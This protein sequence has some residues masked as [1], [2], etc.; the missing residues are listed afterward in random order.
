MRARRWRR[1]NSRFLALARDLSERI[2]RQA[3]RHPIV[4][5]FRANLSVERNR[6]LVPAKY[7]PVHSTAIALEGEASQRAQQR[8]SHAVL[9]RRRPDEEIF[10]INT[11]LA[12]PGGIVVEEERKAGW[13]VTQIGNQH[14]RRGSLSEKCPGDIVVGD[15]GLTRLCPLVFSEL[16]NEL[17][18]EGNVF[19]RCGDYS[20]LD[21][22][23]FGGA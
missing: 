9:P 17:A 23:A 15:G 16:E 6:Q 22:T 13:L 12:E 2:A 1:S 4:H 11:A 18:Y 21:R 7:C 19:L 10:Q 5:G 20:R 14:F 8:E 3:K